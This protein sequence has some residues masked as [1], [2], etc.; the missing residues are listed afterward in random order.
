MPDTVSTPIIQVNSHNLFSTS[1]TFWEGGKVVEIIQLG[2]DDAQLELF[3]ELR[4]YALK[5]AP[6][7]FGSSYEETSQKP[8][9]DLIAQ[10]RARMDS[11][12]VVFVAK[13]A[14]KFVGITG[15]H[16]ESRLKTKHKAYIWGVYVLPELRGRSI[17]RELMQCAIAYAGKIT[18]VKQLQ[19]SVEANNAA[20]VRLYESFGFTIWGT[21]L[22][23]HYVN[24]SYLDAHHMVLNL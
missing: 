21:E 16:R 14:D 22:Q 9:A 12:N 17:A 19:L 15:L 5:D 1:L 11:D 6:E 4:L 13:D 24:D 7:A 18:D 23:S 20:A 3:W 2:D 8:M 10:Q